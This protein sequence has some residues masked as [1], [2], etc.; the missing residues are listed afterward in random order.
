MKKICE[1]PSC[2]IEFEAKRK[3]ARFHNDKCRVEAARAAGVNPGTGE[4][5]DARGVEMN[6]TGPTVG[7]IRS[8]RIPEKDG[9]RLI[10]ASIPVAV[11]GKNYDREKN[12]AAFI[13][14][15]VA[16][17]DWIS[18]GIPEFD[19]LTQIPRGRITQIQGPYGVGKTT[20]CLNMIK[21][22]RDKKVLYIDSEASL[23]PELLVDL[24]LD[25][26]L[27]HLYNESAYLEDISD[28]LRAA[29]KSGAYELVIFD[30]LAMCTTKAIAENDITASNIGQ[31]AKMMHKII[32]LIQM[33]LKDTNTALVVIN[34][35]REVLGGYVPTKYTPGGMAVPYAASLMI[36]LKTIKSW[37]FPQKPKDNVYLGQEVEATIIKSKVNNPW[38]VKK[39][40]LFYPNPVAITEEEAKMNEKDDF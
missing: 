7:K 30:S 9:E 31:K 3:T 18:T 40:K 2:G 27:F 23:N 16:K 35:E 36:A 26:K 19:E 1:N 20:L 6:P 28:I 32:S 8:V 33:D 29:A 15:G 10:E 5:L 22:M 34:Q 37:R 24:E 39:F 4:V 38:R 21:G 12:L 25:P 17:T 11:A 14:M 13:K